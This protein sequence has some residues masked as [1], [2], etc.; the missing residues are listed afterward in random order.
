MDPSFLVSTVQADDGVEDIFLAHF[1][2]LSTNWALFKRHPFMTTVY[3]SSDATSSSIMHHVTK[4]KSSQIGFLNMTMSSLYSNGLHSHQISI[5]R[6]PLGC[7]TGD[8]HH[9]CAAE[10]STATAWCCQCWGK[11]LLKVMHYNITLLP[12]KVHYLVT[13]FKH[14]STYINLINRIYI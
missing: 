4:Q 7:G 10:K 12:K 6:A 8:S 14:W 1:G 13:F 5:S 9:G 2:P 11:L 3:P